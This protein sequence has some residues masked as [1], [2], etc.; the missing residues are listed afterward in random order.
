M[1]VWFGLVSGRFVFEERRFGFGE[2]L[3]GFGSGRFF[4]RGRLGLRYFLSGSVWGAWVRNFSD[5]CVVGFLRGALSGAIMK[6][7]ASELFSRLLFVTFVIPEILN[8]E[9]SSKSKDVA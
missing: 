1:K 2:V 3:F 5:F 7:G 6:V 8:S 4:L 9:N